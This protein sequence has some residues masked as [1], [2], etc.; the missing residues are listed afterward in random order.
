MEIQPV[1]E[2][3]GWL[4]L[5]E[6]LA[7][8][9][10]ERAFLFFAWAVSDSSGTR[11]ASDYFRSQLVETGNDPEHPQVTETEQLLIDWGRLAPKSEVTDD[12]SLRFERAFRPKSRELLYRGVALA[13]ELDHQ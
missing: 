10:G 3:A 7:P 13:R 2:D 11:S 1:T 8:L 4:A 9:I 6:E 12:L 5:R